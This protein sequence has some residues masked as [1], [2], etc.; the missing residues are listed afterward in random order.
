MPAVDFKRILSAA[1]SKAD[2]SDDGGGDGSFAKPS[3][4]NF[5]NGPHLPQVCGFRQQHTDLNTRIIRRKY[6]IAASWA[7]DLWGGSGY[8]SN[9][10]EPEAGVS[11]RRPDVNSWWR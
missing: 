1:D 5:G 10:L 2:N 9:G 4:I 11:P 3:L 8:S 6:S 7:S